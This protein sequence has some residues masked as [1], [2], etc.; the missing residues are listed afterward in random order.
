M[1][2][3][4]NQECPFNNAVHDCTDEYDVMDEVMSIE[5]SL[6]FRVLLVKIVRFE[7]TAARSIK[8]KGEGHPV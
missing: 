8:N 4:Y 7:C 3:Q 5:Q 6:N 1:S 2:S